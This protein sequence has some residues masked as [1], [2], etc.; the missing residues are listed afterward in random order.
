VLVCGRLGEHFIPFKQGLAH[1]RAGVIAGLTVAIAALTLSM[2]VAIDAGVSPAQGLYTGIVYTGIVGGFLVSA[3][4]RLSA[5]RGS[6]SRLNRCDQRL[7]RVRRLVAAP[8]AL[9]RNAC[10]LHGK[11]L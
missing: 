8:P 6:G 3:L 11:G 9:T 1:L 2:A 4:L 10:I 7:L 5:V